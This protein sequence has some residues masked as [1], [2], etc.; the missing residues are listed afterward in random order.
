M[1]KLIIIIAAVFIGGVAN[2]QKVGETNVPA[3]VKSKFVSLYP[4][5]KMEKWKNENG[6][7]QAEFNNNKTE[8]CVTIDAKG[9]LVKTK[10]K[11]EASALPKPAS[12]YLAK[13]YAD[14]KVSAAYKETDAAGKVC[15]KAEVKDQF[16]MFD[17]NGTF[18][19]EKNE[20]DMK[21]D[22]DKK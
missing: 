22:K 1:K 15:Y 12:D 2:A 7:Y 19:K 18:L 13:N 10:T 16:L 5:A 8:M 17:A 20:K 11:I 4:D 21:K 6:N 9:G 14:K 3:V